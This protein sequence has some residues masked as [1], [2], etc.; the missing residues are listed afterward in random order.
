MSQAIFLINGICMHL[1]I[2]LYLLK[3]GCDVLLSTTQKYEFNVEKT[4]EK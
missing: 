3:S 1:F 4:V 2:Y